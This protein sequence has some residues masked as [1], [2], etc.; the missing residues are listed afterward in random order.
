MNS[1]N[2]QWT[3][4]VKG[5]LVLWC[6]VG[7]RQKIQN[8]GMKSTYRE[9]ECIDD[10]RHI[11]TKYY[12]DNKLNASVQQTDI[13]DTYCRKKSFCILSVQNYFVRLSVRSRLA[14]RNVYQ[15]LLGLKFSLGDFEIRHVT[16]SRRVNERA[17]ISYENTTAVSRTRFHNRLFKTNA[18]DA[19]DYFYVIIILPHCPRRNF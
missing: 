4:P 15:R 19:F 7:T 2:Y 12:Y 16:A 11:V 3:C 14:Q 6:N 18:A 10:F 17:R 9:I 8:V 1:S 13:D 5:I